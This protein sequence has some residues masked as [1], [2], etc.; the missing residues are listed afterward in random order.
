MMS[1]DLYNEFV[2]YI[3]APSIGGLVRWIGPLFIGALLTLIK[4]PIVLRNLDS[5]RIFGLKYKVRAHKYLGL[6]DN[7]EDLDDDSRKSANSL[8]NVLF[9]DVK[10]DLIQA[11][12][13]EKYKRWIDRFTS[14][15]LVYSVAWL[16]VMSLFTFGVHLLKLSAG[17]TLV[18]S[19]AQTQYALLI[20]IC[21]CIAMLPLILYIIFVL[22]SRFVRHRRAKILLS[23]K[24]MNE[25]SLSAILLSLNPG[26]PYLFID[27]SVYSD[28]PSS[29]IIGNSNDV[30]ILAYIE[31]QKGQNI[32]MSE[33]LQS[34]RKDADKMATELV[35]NFLWEKELFGKDIV[36][37]VYSRYGLSA[38]QVASVLRARGFAAH[39]IGKSDGRSKELV[40]AIKEVE[41][42]RAC[43]LK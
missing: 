15:L 2:D 34:F 19:D 24:K 4:S 41:L 28:I 36:Y 37:F 31:E 43:G 13:G 18:L 22:P 38:I 26:Q 29:P 17:K 25:L 5:N 8:K 39:Y 7:V 27:A 32:L 21:S 6:I 16:V 40:R 33:L 1:V 9:D 23:R 14:E 42:L 20:I 35:M 12:L 11:Y 10:I 3:S 30:A